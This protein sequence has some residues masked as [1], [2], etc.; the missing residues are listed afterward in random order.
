MTNSILR[1]RVA[2]EK[3]GASEEA[4]REKRIPGQEDRM[5]HITIRG[6][7]QNW[8][9]ILQAAELR[10][11]CSGDQMLSESDASSTATGSGL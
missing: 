1:E 8:S 11:Y 7:A 6:G 4:Y 10:I 2:L 3:R 5:A 9:G